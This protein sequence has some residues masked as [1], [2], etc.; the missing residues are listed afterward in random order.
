MLYFSKY[1]CT[2]DRR[3]PYSKYLHMMMFYA[4]N[5]ID[6][7]GYSYSGLLTHF[8]TANVKKWRSAESE[9]APINVF[10]S[11]ILLL[12]YVIDLNVTMQTV[13]FVEFKFI[14][15]PLR[16]LSP[17]SLVLLLCNVL[18]CIAFLEWL[19]LCTVSSFCKHTVFSMSYAP[20]NLCEGGKM[21]K[22]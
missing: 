20:L 13:L 15:Q 4:M 5:C 19:S 2:G 14:P 22:R 11:T 3:L 1:C 16:C 10:N 7:E 9:S 18:L 17:S 8:C 12:F 6:M 21:P